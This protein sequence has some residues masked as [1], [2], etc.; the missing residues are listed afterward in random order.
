MLEYLDYNALNAYNGLRSPAGTVESDMNTRYYARC[1]FQRLMSRIRFTLPEDWNYNYFSQVLLRE[2]FI[3]IVNTEEYGVIPQICTLQGYGIYLQPIRLIVA[4]P[5]VRFTG[6]I[7]KDCEL[8][9]LTPD[10]HGIFD[11]VEHYALQLSMAFTSVKMSEYNNRLAYIV[12]AKNKKM[13]ETAKYIFEKISSGEP[14]VVT[15]KTILSDDETGE[16]QLFTEAFD[17]SRN[18]ITDKLLENITTILYQFDRE[19][20][21]PTVDQ[22]KERM[23]TDEAAYSVTDSGARLDTWD[24]C[25][26]E[27]F[28]NTNR[29]FPELNLSYEIKREVSDNVSNA[30]NDAD[31]DV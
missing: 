18:F 15:D 24:Q 5:L 6:D 28:A 9:R 31:R 14:L 25:L 3:G 27:T 17:V 2:G 22:K 4:Q 23:I 13:A 26:K 12:G 21:I 20:G 10:Y 30:E 7:G 29:L 11:I 1:L 19:I 16:S 8:I